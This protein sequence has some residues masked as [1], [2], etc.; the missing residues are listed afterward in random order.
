MYKLAVKSKRLFHLYHLGIEVE[1]PYV[2]II[3]NTCEFLDFDGCIEYWWKSLGREIL[4]VNNKKGKFL[5]NIITK[6]NNGK[7]RNPTNEP[8]YRD[9]KMSPDYMKMFYHLCYEVVDIRLI[10]TT[11]CELELK[12]KSIVFDELNL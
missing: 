12:R 2:F 1:E 7:N 6:W 5:F 9:I 3:K 4:S 8:Y 11:I 10:I